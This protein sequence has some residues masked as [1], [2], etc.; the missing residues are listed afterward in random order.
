MGTDNHPGGRIRRF[1]PVRAH[2]LR[3]CSLTD[4]THTHYIPTSFTLVGNE[5]ADIEPLVLTV[6]DGYTAAIIAYGQ[7]GSGKTFT[8]NGY[9]TEHGVSYRTLNQLFQLL[10]FRKVEAANRN[11]WCSIL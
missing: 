2:P 5:H 8:M 7:T 10:E 3:T 9:G 11:R 1:H 6:V 4:N